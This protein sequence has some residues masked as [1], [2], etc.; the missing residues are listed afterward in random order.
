MREPGVSSLGARKVRRQGGSAYL[1]T[2]LALVVLTIAGLSV[3]LMTQTEQQLAANERTMQESFYAADSGMA[4]A[5]AKGLWRNDTDPVSF[6]MNRRQRNV[7]NNLWVASRV[8]VSEMA[9]ISDLVPC[10]L[11]QINQGSE[12]YAINH[13]VTAFAERIAWQGSEM[14]TTD[15]PV[16]GRRTLGKMIELQ[17]WQNEPREGVFVIRGGDLKVQY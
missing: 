9:Q 7:V 8:R 5:T 16:V 6:L 1:L 4:V 10:S 12:F 3:S 2:L 17:P 11:C 13:A 15:A 14:P